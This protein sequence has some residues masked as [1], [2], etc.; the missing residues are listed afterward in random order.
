MMHD[1]RQMTYSLRVR[2]RA[3]RGLDARRDPA[4]GLREALRKSRRPYVVSISGTGRPVRRVRR[5]LLRSSG[6]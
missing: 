1:R 3:D 2:P 6:H 5:G 4:T